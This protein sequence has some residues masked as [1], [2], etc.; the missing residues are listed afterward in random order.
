MLSIFLIKT[1]G[2]PVGNDGI[3]F[4]VHMKHCV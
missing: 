2:R 3:L 1:F 4:P